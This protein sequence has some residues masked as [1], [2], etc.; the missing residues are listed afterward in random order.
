M[1]NVCNKCRY[2]N[3]YRCSRYVCYCIGRSD[4]FG[5]DFKDKEN[6]TCEYF[7]KGEKVEYVPMPIW[8]S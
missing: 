1:E 8:N 3:G 6:N 4:M 2:Y 5:S 7:E